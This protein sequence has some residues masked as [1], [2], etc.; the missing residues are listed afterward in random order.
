M[1]AVN[2]ERLVDDY[3]RRL[4]TAATG[5]A[6][7]DRAELVAEIREHIHSALRTA[8]GPEEVAVRNVLE[9]LGPPEEIAGAAG[10][11]ALDAGSR[12]VDGRDVAG[13]VVLAAGS[14][15]RSSGCSWGA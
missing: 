13:F 7:D 15:C 9:R 5:L 1:L 10:P 2:V 14:W 12:P 3:L 11:V 8:D 4:E 6:L